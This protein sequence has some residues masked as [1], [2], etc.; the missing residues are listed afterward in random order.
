MLTVVFLSSPDTAD[1]VHTAE[2]YM[3]PPWPYDPV[4]S[5][6]KVEQ[7]P[8]VVG[9]VIITAGATGFSGDS[10]TTLLKAVGFDA[11]TRT[12][13]L[14]NALS[15]ELRTVTVSPTLMKFTLLEASITTGKDAF[16]V[17]AFS[18]VHVILEAS[19][20]VK[21]VLH[22]QATAVLPASSVGASNLIR[23]KSPLSANCDEM[24]FGAGKADVLDS[25]WTVVEGLI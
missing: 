10:I 19:V 11:Q 22:A 20:K 15:F 8:S 17:A 14:Q 3:R 5:K 9:A 18:H 21:S 2:V 4:A 24:I 1:T 7:S 25:S 13:S 12:P 6:T 23:K 16:T